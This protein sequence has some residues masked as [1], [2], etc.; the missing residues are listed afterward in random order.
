M[1]F[2]VTSQLIPSFQ[3]AK[4]QLIV[5]TQEDVQLAQYSARSEVRSGEE[6][7]LPAG[8]RGAATVSHPTVQ[9]QGSTILSP[10]RK[11]QAGS[12]PRLARG[13][14][15]SILPSR[16]PKRCTK[17]HNKS[18]HSCNQ[19]CDLPKFDTA[20]WLSVT[21]AWQYF[22]EPALN[23]KTEAFMDRDM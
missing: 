7:R 12:A 3:S 17:L 8:E 13:E 4:M 2:T 18:T 23:E 22:A 1:N 5:F 9:S 14:N 19:L 16:L 15:K 6:L 21:S 10:L 11:S 20:T